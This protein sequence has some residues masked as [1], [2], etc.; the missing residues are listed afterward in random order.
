MKEQIISESLPKH[1]AVIMD[2]NGR[3]AKKK[4]AA[5]IFGHK[6]AIKAVRDVT[7]G[8][9]ELGV[10][11]LTLYAF[12][13][14]NWSRPKV[15]VNA[16]MEL[17]VSTLVSEMKTLMD[18]GIRLDTIG[19]TKSLP[20]KCQRELAEAMAKTKNNDRMVLVLA[21]SYSGRWDIA[22]ATKAIAK[23]VAEGKV[24]AENIDQE[25]INKYLNTSGIP[26]PELLIRTSGEQRISNFLL[27]QMAYTEFY[28]TD[29]LWPDYRKKDLYEAIVS[30]QNRERRF[31]MTSEQIKS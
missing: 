12:S 22:Q 20:E 4:G 10:E 2:G 18:N 8:C 6:N 15:E 1:I 29:T 27:W 30:Y 13:T 31:G 3:W 25:L 19:D 9:A 23:D 21:L 14:E 16:L 5:R 7:E 26:D 28:I 11:Y 24:D 17:L